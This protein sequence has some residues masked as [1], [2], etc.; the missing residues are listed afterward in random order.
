M[1]TFLHYGLTKTNKVVCASESDQ[2]S[3]EKD[4]VIPVVCAV[5]IGTCQDLLYY[6]YLS[7]LKGCFH[8]QQ[9]AAHFVYFFQWMKKM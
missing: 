2:V 4:K 6:P 8:K 9:A 7:M 5:Y 1:S 3:D